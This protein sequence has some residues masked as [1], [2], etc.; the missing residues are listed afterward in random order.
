MITPKNPAVASW[1]RCWETGE[2]DELPISDNF[3]HSSPFGLIEGKQRYLEIVNKN[4]NDFLGNTLTVLKE[5]NE[6]NKVCVQFKQENNNTGLEMVVCEWY[7]IE[8][9]TILSIQSFYNIGN[10]EIKG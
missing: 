3:S 10:A 6:A 4:R 5:I 2:L 8:N 1:F 7:E 9:N